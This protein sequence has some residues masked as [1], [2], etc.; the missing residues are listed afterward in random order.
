MGL[1]GLRS[2]FSFLTRRINN[3]D[4]TSHRLGHVGR[5]CANGFPPHPVF[6][7]SYATHVQVDL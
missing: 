5:R 6:V 7:L 2:V 4:T 3:K 1:V